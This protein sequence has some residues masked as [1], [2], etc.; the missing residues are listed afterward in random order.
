MIP[1]EK[2]RHVVFRRDPAIVERIEGK[3]IEAYGTELTAPWEKPRASGIS[4][5]DRAQVLKAGLPAGTIIKKHLRN[6]LS[7]RIG[8][9]VHE[10]IQEAGWGD[11][12]IAEETIEN[13]WLRGHSDHRFVADGILVDY[14]TA[15]VDDWFDV[16]VGIRPQK[17]EHVVQANWYAVMHG[18]STVAIVYFNRNLKLTDHLRRTSEWTRLLDHHRGA[19][20][21]MTAIAFQADP[22]LARA[23]DRKAAR[24]LAHVAAGVLPEYAPLPEMLLPYKGECHF[25]EVRQ[26]CHQAKDAPPVAESPSPA[27]SDDLPVEEW[28][29][30]LLEDGR[31]IRIHWQS[32]PSKVVGTTH[33]SDIPWGNLKPGDRLELV[34][35]TLNPNGP[36]FL[37]NFAQAIKVVHRETGAFLGYL[38]ATKSSTAGKVCWHLHRLGLIDGRAGDAFAVIT[39]LTGGT[40]EKANRGIN[41]QITL[42]APESPLPETAAPAQA[43]AIAGK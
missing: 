26:L 7:T 25:C 20:E 38:P 14:K 2:T 6:F 30:L 21:T 29:S 28:S 19:S 3:L 40:E 1:A 27:P 12:A 34:W 32:W 22:A 17:T 10:L 9:F 31:S 36:R 16:A 13:A 18:C 24:I 15:F 23:A 42:C 8:T 11:E 35:D 4:A 37:E 39:E 33:R 5:C 41:L 43:P